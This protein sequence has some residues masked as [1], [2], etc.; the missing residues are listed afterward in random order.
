MFSFCSGRKTFQKIVKRTH[1]YNPQLAHSDTVRSFITKL[2]ENVKDN[3]VE[4]FL[5]LMKRCCHMKRIVMPIEF[6]ADHP[7][8]QFGRLFLACLLKHHELGKLIKYVVCVVRV[9]LIDRSEKA[10]GKRDL[11]ISSIREQ[12]TKEPLL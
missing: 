2:S 10:R 4:K 9:T 11:S 6:P 1:H 5:S 3:S 8:E 7:V 12:K